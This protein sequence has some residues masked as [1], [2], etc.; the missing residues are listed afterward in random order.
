MS[1]DYH[2]FLVV[3]QWVGWVLGGVTSAI[4]VGHYISEPL[5]WAIFA[6]FS[7]LTGGFCMLRIHAHNTKNG[8]RR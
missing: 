3:V 7:F 6:A 1:E 4:S 5:G 8:G 2:Y